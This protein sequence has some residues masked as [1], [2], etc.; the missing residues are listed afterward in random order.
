MKIIIA[1]DS[2]KKCLTATQVARHI[3]SGIHSVYPSAEII[4]IPIP[5]VG[6]GTFEAMVTATNGTIIRVGSVDALMRPIES[7]FGVL[8]NGTTVVIEMAAAS[9]IELIEPSERNPMEASTFG[10]GLLI[11]EA[12][13][14]GFLDFIIA[15]GGSATND[16]GVGMAKALADKPMSMEES[17]ENSGQLLKKTSEQIMRVITI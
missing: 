10:T 9:G 8:G 3:S 6:E 12:L 2:F 7:F 1:T 14:R 15:I 13:E 11:K 17:K 5:D 4:R 16:G